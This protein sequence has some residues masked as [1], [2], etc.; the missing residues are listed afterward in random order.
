MNKSNI[1]LIGMAGV[2]KSYL[3]KRLAE[4]LGYE[5]IEIDEL[6]TKEAEKEGLD[7]ATISDAE[8]IRLEEQAVLSLK[9]KERCVFDTGGSVVYSESAMQF[10]KENAQIIYLRDTPERI[11]ERFENR[12]PVRLIDLAGKNFTSLLHERTSLYEKYADEI[13]EVSELEKGN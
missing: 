7:K 10:L 9:G 2:G 6:I 3:S 8:F 5:A 4:Q 11:R 1:A 13:I 12:A